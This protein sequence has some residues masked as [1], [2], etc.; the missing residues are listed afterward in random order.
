MVKV[1][2]DGR[3]VTSVP[4]L[5]SASPTDR[6]RRDGVAV[7]EFHEVLLAVA[8]DREL[9][10]G[11][12]RVDHRDADAVQAAGDLVGVLVEF[13][14][15]MQLGHDDLG[16]RDAFALV[17][18]GRDAAAVVAHGAGAVRIERDR[19]LGGV[20]GERLV[21]GVVDDLVDHVVQAGAVVGVADIHAGPLAHGVEALEDLDRFRIVIGRIRAVWRAGSA[22]SRTFESRS[23]KRVGTRFGLTRKGGA[24][25]AQLTAANILIRRQI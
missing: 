12:Q 20:A 24:V 11:R 14:A 19:H 6:E 13:S 16:R 18:V 7:A 8:P 23:K 5:P 25:Q 22:M 2:G 9:E 10:P 4:R 15:G 17:D 3:N 1:F 21:D